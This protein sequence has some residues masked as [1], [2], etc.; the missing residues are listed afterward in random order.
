MIQTLPLKLKNIT[1]FFEFNA[2]VKAYIID[3]EVIEEHQLTVDDE[4]YFLVNKN[5]LFSLLPFLI[6]NNEDVSFST[7]EKEFLKNYLIQ[8]EKFNTEI[9]DSLK[10]ENP[11]YKGLRERFKEDISD[12]IK[13][14]KTYD[15]YL[16]ED[17][18]LVLD[19]FLDYEDIQYIFNEDED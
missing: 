3:D 15:H 19:L 7:E 17:E 2:G 9:E 11:I 13:G 8:D 12:L 4:F 10:K 5:Y 16:L 1:P 18:T 14:L 6:V